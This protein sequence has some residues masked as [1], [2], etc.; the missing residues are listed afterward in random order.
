MKYI[1]RERQ[2]CGRPPEACGDYVVWNEVQ[3]V[4]GRK[5]VWRGDL[6]EHA[7]RWIAE[8]GAAQ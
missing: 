5:V 3:V 1:I 8:Q 6:R 2:R 7:E 4:Y